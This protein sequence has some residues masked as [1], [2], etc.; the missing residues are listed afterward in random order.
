MNTNQ[1]NQPKGMPLTI[2]AKFFGGS[3]SSGTFQTEPDFNWLQ[4]YTRTD[5]H[6]EALD[7]LKDAIQWLDSWITLSVRDQ[8]YVSA[9]E[10]MMLRE[11][12]WKFK[13]ACEK[14]LNEHEKH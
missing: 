8:T 2:H 5:R 14:I 7:A 4:S 10:R 6:Q 11:S 3:R 12:T 9:S 1:P 13:Q